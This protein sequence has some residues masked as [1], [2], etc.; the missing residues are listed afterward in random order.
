VTAAAAHL[1]DI[2]FCQYCF[3]KYR[4]NRGV[5]N[6]IDTWLYDHG[7][8]NVTVRRELALAFLEFHHRTEPLEEGMKFYK[9]GKGNLVERLAAFV[10][11]SGFRITQDHDVDRSYGG[12]L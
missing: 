2:R 4:L 11:H 12:L 7:Y 10:R 3:E 1:P 6:T 8:R 9:F 5:Y